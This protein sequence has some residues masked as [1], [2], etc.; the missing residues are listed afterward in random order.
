MAKRWYIVHA[1][2]NFENKVA[3][4]I[5]EK[6]RAA[7]PVRHVR[8][9]PG[10]DRE[11]RRDAPRPQGRCRAQVLPGL[12]AGED[13]YDR[14]G[15]PPDQE[16]AEGHG[17]PRRRQQADADLRRREAERILEQVQEG[18]ERPKPSVSFEIGEQVRVS[19]GPF[20]S[21]NGVVEEVDE[22]PRAPQ[23]GSFD[24]RPRRRRSS[25]NTGRSRR[26]DP[27]VALMRRKAGSGVGK[28]PRRMQLETAGSRDAAVSHGPAGVAAD[29]DCNRPSVKPGVRPAS[30]RQEQTWQRRS[31]VT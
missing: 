8:G 18:V 6:A 16:H 15:V 28:L 19:D 3:E 20:A 25:W 27:T 23:G 12:R 5:R 24:L 22:E 26:S 31:R 7:R 30:E 4:S 9:D 10:A 14:R 17:L 29:R 13:G 21:F 11:G 2:S 1:Y